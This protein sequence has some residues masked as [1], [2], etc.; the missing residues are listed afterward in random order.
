[1]TPE[2]L[3]EIRGLNVRYGQSHILQGVDLVVGAEPLAL[4]GRNGM[5]KSTLCNAIVGLVPAT[6]TVRLGGRDLT[7][8][9]PHDIARA[10]IGYVPQGRRIFPSL[11]VDEHLRLVARRNEHG[12]TIR[13]VYELF[14]PLAA[15]RRNGGAQL[16]GG[17]QQMLAIA[18]A[19][20]L[21]PRLLVMDEPSEG[22]A[23]V[24]V[25]HLATVL[26]EL[27][28]EGVGL[29]LVEQNL[30]VATAV[31][32]RIAI[33][34]TGRIALETTSEALLAD[35][36]AQRRYLGVGTQVASAEL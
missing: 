36:A 33:M 14:P 27:T 11:S 35:K 31:A 26:R 9:R 29:L 5:G 10:G 16:S 30:G 8:R 22:L 20:L 1:M 12:W 15:R 28:R 7:G 3:L 18:R 6:G 17:E 32:D 24:V 4:I 13:R 21:N 23:P 34:V 25:E 19:L 2:A